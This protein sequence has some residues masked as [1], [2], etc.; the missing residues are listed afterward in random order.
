M[1]GFLKLPS[2][3]TDEIF[4][5]ISRIDLYNTSLTCRGLYEKSISS[6]NRFLKITVVTSTRID[7]ARAKKIFSRAFTD[8]SLEYLRELEVGGDLKQKNGRGIE[9][10]H[11][12]VAPSLEI[13]GNISGC[14]V[15]AMLNQ[16]LRDFLSRLPPQQLKKFS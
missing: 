9:P 8:V 15:E 14:N 12:Y 11:I 16:N 7:E 6:I 13:G 10:R 1:S 4:G 5:R 3:L 2:E